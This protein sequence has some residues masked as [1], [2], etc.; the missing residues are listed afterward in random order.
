MKF[1]I[2]RTEYLTMNVLKDFQRATVERIDDLF[3]KGQGRILVADE[4]GMGK[5]L[6]ARGVIVK[7]ARLQLEKNDDLFKVVYIC[8]NISIAN[9]NIRK[10]KVSDS[11][12]I[13]GVS[14]TRLSMQHLKITQQELDQNIRDG[15]IQLIPLTPDTS[16]RMTTGGGT[17]NE[18]ALMYAI[19]CRMSEFD[20]VLPELRRF[21]KYSVSKEDSWNYY[22]DLY[23][24]HVKSCE[25]RT[26]GRYPNDLIKRI[27]DY[28]REESIIAILK[29]HLHE[30]M[31]QQ[32]PSH[33]GMFVLNKLRVMFARLSTQMLEP[34]LVIMDE[35]QRFR[36]LINSDR[37]SDTGILAHQFLDGGN[38][39]ILLLS[40]TP[41]KLYSTL[42]E[43][44]DAAGVDE[45]Y[46]EFLQVMDFLFKGDTKD[47]RKVWSDYN[48]A[49]HELH[50]GDISIIRVK[51]AAEDAM[52][53]GVCRT[54]R[55]S[56]ME[57]GDYT[58]DS[59]VKYPIP[60]SEEDIRSFLAMGTLLKEIGAPFSLPVDYAK[61]SPFLMSFMRNY[62]VKQYI[63]RHFQKHADDLGL[64]EK[65][66]LWV[67][68]EAVNAYHPL[69]ASNARLEKLKELA[70]ENNAEMYLWVPPSRPYYKLQ[71]VYSNSH[72]F[73]KI[74]VFSAWEMVPRMIGAMVSYEAECR[75]VG[76]VCENAEGIEEKNKTYNAERRYPYPRLKFSLRG[77]TPQRMTLFCLLY[78]SATLADF[79]DPIQALNAGLTLSEIENTIRSKVRSSLQDLRR[80]ATAEMRTSDARWYYLAPMLMDGIEYTENWIGALNSSMENASEDGEDGISSDRGNKAFSMHV[81][82]LL[83][84]ISQGENLSLGP[85]PEDLTE[86]LVNMTLGSPAICIYRSNRKNVVYATA[87]AKTFLNYFNT[88]EST[89]V[90]QLAAE[91]YRDE[92]Q[93]DAVYWKDV[94]LYCKNGCFQA[95]FDEYRHLISDAAGF[96]APSQKEARI[97]R[98]MLDDLRIHTASYDVDTFEKFQ[99]RIMGEKGRNLMRAHY[100]VGFVNSEG[101]DNQ[102]DANRKDSI[103]GAFNSPLKPFVLATTSIGQEGLDFHNYCRRIMHWNLP[104]NPIDLEQREGR[105]NRFKCL[106]IR[107]NVAEKYGS[108]HFYDDIWKEMFDAAEAEKAS[109]QSDLVPYWCFGKDQSI[110]IERIVPMY[111]MSKDEITYER[112][113]KILSLY[114]LTLGQARQEELL[115]YLFHECKNP[116]ELKKLFIDLSPF[117]KKGCSD[118]KPEDTTR[119]SETTDARENTKAK[120][121]SG[122]ELLIERAIQAYIKDFGDNNQ[123]EG[124]SQRNETIKWTAAANFAVNWNVDADDMFSMW[125]RCTKE[126]FIDTQHNHPSQGITLLLKIPSEVE[127]VRKAF[128]DLFVEETGDPEAKWERV[129][130]FMDYING[131]ITD[132][133]PNSSVYLQTKEAVLTYLNLWDPDHNYRYK[134]APANNWASYMGYIDW[135]SGQRFSLRK[136]YRMCD[137][138][139][140]VVKNHE[141]LLRV[142]RQRFEN[143]EPDYDKEFHILTFDVLYCFWSYEDARREALEEYK[144]AMKQ[145]QIDDLEEQLSQINT[146]IKAKEGMI[147]TPNCVGIKVRHKKYGIGEVAGTANE[148]VTVLFEDEGPKQF[149]YPDAF[150]K[151]F[152]HSEDQ[153]FMNQI[154]LNKALEDSLSELKK[155]AAELSEKLSV[156]DIKPEKK[157]LRR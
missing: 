86:T 46:K 134:P 106:A 15:Y 37:E 42:E 3:R 92:D 114:R 9:Q 30:R 49:L 18:R 75:T 83:E 145:Q 130:A 80:F 16:F 22:I 2:D 27:R 109:S 81:G 153:A 51:D 50:D 143:G 78:P 19:I 7:T 101:T 89:A 77:D 135:E 35:F 66:L 65:D 69:P 82:R 93:D 125:K 141:E 104:G 58:D 154:Q 144:E 48:V 60:V 87:L 26:Q 70:F 76:R 98:T 20:D 115:E 47:F 41:Y 14:D 118:E 132:L 124:S 45:H 62:K 91:Q 156:L 136:Y 54:E 112:L 127:G 10:L 31:A 21:L 122:K 117:S 17:V 120:K 61:S 116:E 33:N 11:V 119:E 147:G 149:L 44:D 142:H 68:P 137:E 72:H 43:I 84:L 73:S 88:T 123:H 8:S 67:D 29:Q 85:M 126:A 96:S 53:Q 12:T 148:K 111:P 32:H 94:L 107:Q 90:I 99:N 150:E 129:L 110:K 39:R 113:I 139:Q 128:R 52:Y 57:S 6:I 103:R 95:M 71:G 34:D 5:T 63:E 25:D 131:R 97:Q 36:F 40:A 28:D 155:K 4:V 24:G 146:E 138:I 56:V 64:A 151:G 152:L 79:Y 100:A 102:K 55:I 74:L 23:E 59:S 121:L 108:I 133:Y 157:T 13:E 1:D 38:V 140:E 105:I